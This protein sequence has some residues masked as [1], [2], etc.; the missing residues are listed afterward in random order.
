M[1]VI[2]LRTLRLRLPL[3]FVGKSKGVCKERDATGRFSFLSHARVTVSAITPHILFLPTTPLVNDNMFRAAGRSSVQI[4]RRRLRTQPNSRLLSTTSSSANVQTR[5]GPTLV[6]GACVAVTTLAVGAYLGSRQT[7]HNDAAINSSVYASQDEKRGGRMVSGSAKDLEDDGHLG[8]LVW[9]SNKYV[10]FVLH[11]Y[12]TSFIYCQDQLAFPRR[13]VYRHFPKSM[14]CTMAS[15]C[16]L[17]RPCF[18]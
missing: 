16:S 14:Q 8:T 2:F 11:T 5:T 1:L 12:V 10:F 6:K 18:T 3:V 7:V 17:T 4:A 13:P 9:G 15:G